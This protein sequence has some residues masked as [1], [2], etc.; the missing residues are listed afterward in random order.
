MG[1]ITFEDVRIDRPWWWP[2]W[3]GPQ[4]Q[5][6]PHSALG[7]KCSLTYPFPDACP[8]QGCV[9]FSD[10]LLR[11][12]RIVQP[13]LSPGVILG[14]ASN[15]MINVTFDDVVVDF[16]ARPLEGRFPWGRKYQC[17]HANVRSLGA[18]QPVPQC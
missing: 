17:E 16:G 8:T 9:T 15:P 4:Q 18:T 14:N 5:Q 3:I 2:V 10:I 6:E 13:L 1:G 12:V 11:N 7:D